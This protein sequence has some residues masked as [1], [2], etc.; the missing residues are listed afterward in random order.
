MVTENRDESRKWIRVSE[1]AAEIGKDKQTLMRW[2]K[3]S[4][5]PLEV[6]RDAGGKTPYT[7]RE[8]LDRCRVYVGGQSTV[9]PKANPAHEAAMRYLR[10][11]C[12]M[13]V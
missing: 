4:V 6:F 13:N 3:R 10:E 1:A 2:A 8:A 7:T 11:V 12:G 9:Q 5:N